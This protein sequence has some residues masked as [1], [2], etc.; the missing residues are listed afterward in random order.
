MNITFW[1]NFILCNILISKIVVCFEYTYFDHKCRDVP[2]YKLIL[3][4][5]VNS[6]HKCVEQCLVRQNCFS[7]IYKRLFPLCELY[8]VDISVLKSTKLGTSCIVI[9][10]KDIN[11]NGTEVLKSKELLHVYI[12][13]QTRIDLIDI[14][15]LIS[16]LQY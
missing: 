2:N 9:R 8:S 7:L 5:H 10:R 1:T 12:P 3:T 14:G 13:N 4:L 6:L 16:K 15:F 11:L